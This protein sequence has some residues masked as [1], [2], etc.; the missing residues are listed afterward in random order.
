M[1]GWTW[2]CIFYVVVFC[3]SVL[4][5]LFVLRLWWHAHTIGWI[6]SS[7]D[8]R[9]MYVDTAK[10]LITASGIAVALLASG[11]SPERTADHVVAISAKVAVVC[12]I[13]CVGLSLVAMLALIRSHE[14]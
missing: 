14:E 10:T 12:L 6:Y 5:F 1:I 7:E 11:L 2:T 3:L 9:N 13:C 4:P 8:S